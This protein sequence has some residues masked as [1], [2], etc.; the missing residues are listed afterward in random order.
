MQS[1]N[2]DDGKLALPDRARLGYLF[3]FPGAYQPGIAV[4]F[5]EGP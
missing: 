3:A 1:A 5:D 2:I 4:T